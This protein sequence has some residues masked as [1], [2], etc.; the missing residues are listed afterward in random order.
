MSFTFIK[1]SAFPRIIKGGRTFFSACFSVLLLGNT[2]ENQ[3]WAFHI[4]DLVKGGVEVYA[5]YAET[6]KTVGDFSHPDT[7][8]IRQNIPK[9]TIK[10]TFRFSSNRAVPASASLP[11]IDKTFFTR[12]FIEHIW[13][14]HNFSQAGQNHAVVQEEI[15]VVIPPREGCAPPD[16]I[17]RIAFHDLNNNGPYETAE[18]QWRV[19]EYGIFAYLKHRL[20]SKKTQHEG[21]TYQT[22]QVIR[23]RNRHGA[24]YDESESLSF[25]L[26]REIYASQQEEP[27][28]RYWEKKGL[29]NPLPIL[30]AFPETLENQNPTEVIFPMDWA[31]T[32]YDAGSPL[33]IIVNHSDTEIRLYQE[34]H[35]GT[36]RSSRMTPVHQIQY[37]ADITRLGLGFRFYDRQVL[38]QFTVWIDTQGYVAGWEYREQSG[39]QRAVRYLAIQ[40]EEQK[41]VLIT[42]TELNPNY[43]SIDSMTPPPIPNKKV[44]RTNERALSVSITHPHNMHAS[45][46]LNEA[47]PRSKLRGIRPNPRST[48][49]SPGGVRLQQAAGNWY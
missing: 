21:K 39:E 27:L 34:A 7:R 49:V 8:E 42:T 32:P 14:L 2:A 13:H 43:E 29:Q 38:T 40:P 23:Y 6:K 24:Y 44:R 17:T 5:G 19:R 45:L 1:T 4:I 41:K 28:S 25:D 11:L 15:Y 47:T 18:Q 46:F 36:I 12:S 3:A 22:K 26:E 37:S 31:R 20:L 16:I 33:P 9:Y 10:S 35:G 30:T 48:F